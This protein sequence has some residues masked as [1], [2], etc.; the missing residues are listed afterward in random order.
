[1][2]DQAKPLT[3]E[4]V[5]DLLHRLA[6]ELIGVSGETARGDTAIKAAR[7]TLINLVAALILANEGG[8]S[9][10]ET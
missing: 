3:D 2:T 9:S 6:F 8:P 7:V 1:M 5:Q 4:E 10:G